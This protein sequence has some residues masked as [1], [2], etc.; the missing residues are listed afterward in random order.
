MNIVIVSTSVSSSVGE[1]Q[2]AGILVPQVSNIS[3]RYEKENIMNP[4]SV[5]CDFEQVSYIS[6]FYVII[7]YSL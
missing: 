5:K 3:Q 2:M 4:S 1:I 6:G 7:T